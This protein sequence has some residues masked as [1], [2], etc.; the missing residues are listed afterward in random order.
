MNKQVRIKSEFVA[1][2]V[3][4]EESPPSVRHQQPLAP[5]F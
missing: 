1:I 5:P 4:A 3:A 2:K